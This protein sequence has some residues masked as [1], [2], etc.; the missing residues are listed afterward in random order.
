VQGDDGIATYLVMAVAELD[1]EKRT[2]ISETFSIPAQYVLTEAEYK[3]ATGKELAWLEP[4][5]GLNAGDMLNIAGR[6]VDFGSY[7]AA[8]PLTCHT[9][10]HP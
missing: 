1:T 9:T 6:K 4:L 5:P 10:L 8:C 2:L 7:R 3:K